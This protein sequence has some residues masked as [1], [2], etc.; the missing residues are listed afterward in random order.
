MALRV[1]EDIKSRVTYSTVLKKLN[2]DD[3]ETFILRELDAASLPH[4][5]F[6]EEALALII[7]S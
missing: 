7:R 1:N 3:M 4:N 6:T 5:T 2:S